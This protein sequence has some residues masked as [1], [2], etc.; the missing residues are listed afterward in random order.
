MTARLP[1]YEI[2]GLGSAAAVL[3]DIDG[4]LLTSGSVA[5]R[6]FLEAVEQVGG[7]RPNPAGI[8]FGGRI[9]PEIA[10]LL[11]A[12]IGQDAVL[13]PAVLARLAELVEERSEALTAHTRA[14]AGVEPLLHRLA[15][16][17]VR[18]TVVTGNIRSVAL[19]K[20]DAASLIPPIDPAYGG[21][22]DSGVTR[23]EVARAA[24]LS[25]FGP[26]WPSMA[27]SCW[28]IGDT[29]RDQACAQALGLRC[30]LVATGRH[31]VA[32]LTGL[33]AD[34]VLTSLDDAAAV[35]A[36]WRDM[37]ITS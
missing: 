27:R 16:A 9:D 13:V 23:V 31:D 20:L 3:W 28:I 12:A 37:C 5:A 22:G 17:G 36:L 34:L 10:T 4:T 18:Q 26:T 15:G 32:A 7:S 29:A 2:T 24:L 25:L 11:L 30:A 33:G 14:L 19:R 21:Y 6:A 1:E 8:D 35:E